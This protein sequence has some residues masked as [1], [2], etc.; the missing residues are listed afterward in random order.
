MKKILKDTTSFVGGSLLL[1]GSAA[2]V[3]SA[4]PGSAGGLTAMSS[5]MPAIGRLTMTG[6]MARMTSKLLPKKKKGRL[7]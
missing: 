3:G 7:I 5:M 1:G 4:F 2:V 6:H